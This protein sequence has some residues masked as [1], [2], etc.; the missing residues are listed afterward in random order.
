MQRLL[1]IKLKIINVSRV[2]KGKKSHQQIKRDKKGRKGILFAMEIKF[3]LFY[4]YIAYS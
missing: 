3:I 2:I 1:A 4:C